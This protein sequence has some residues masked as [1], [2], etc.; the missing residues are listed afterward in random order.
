MHC[1]LSSVVVRSQSVTAAHCHVW[2]MQEWPRM[3]FHTHTQSVQLKAWPTH[4]PAKVLFIP[5]LLK[6]ISIWELEFKQRRVFKKL[7]LSDTIYK[8]QSTK[9]HIMLPVSHCGISGSKTLTVTPI[10]LFDF[11]KLWVIFLLQILNKLFGLFINGT[12]QL[13]PQSAVV[14]GN[15]KWRLSFKN[16]K[17]VYSIWKFS[18]WTLISGIRRYRHSN[19]KQHLDENIS[20][21]M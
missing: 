21:K 1:E 11:L 17:S 19:I 9:S 14:C 4:T 20:T 18:Q 5:W 15:L 12:T 6:T 8:N 3:A 16:L 10:F 7:H 2:H 13:D